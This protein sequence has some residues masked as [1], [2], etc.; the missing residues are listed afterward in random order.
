MNI[1]KKEDGDSLTLALEGRLD[2]AT[3]PQLDELL[4]KELDGVTGLTFDFSSLE[5]LSSAGLRVLLAAHKRM[6]GKGTMLV[7]NVNS[8]VME[9]FEITG[10]SDI[11]TIR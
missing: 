5:Y 7:T 10:F 3:S 4:Q 2:T 6:K 8:T 11:L 9:I 1:H